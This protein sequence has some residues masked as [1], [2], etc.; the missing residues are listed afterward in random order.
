LAKPIRYNPGGMPPFI[1]AKDPLTSAEWAALN[2]T[3][4][5]VGNSTVARRIIETMGPLGAGIQTV[6]NEI[7][8]GITEGYKSILGLNGSAI[9]TK[10]RES[11]VVPIIFKDF[12]VHW[13]DLEEARLTGQGFSRAKAAAAA[14]SCARAE[15]KLVLFG[16]GRLGYE[17][18]MTAEGRNVITGFE[19]ERPGNAFKN[20]TSMIKVLA[21]KGYSGPY[22]AIAHPKIYTGMHRVLAGSSLLEIAHV[23]ALLT[24]GVFRSELL[25][26]ETGLVIATGRQNF[27]LVIAVDT[28]AAFLGARKMNLPF[29]VLKSIYL[30][31]R[32]SDA[33]CTFAPK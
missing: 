15:D 6:P 33:I 3:I 30:R 13:R 22:A 24:A 9:K 11:A 27:E 14:S 29:R 26:P 23:R 5:V 19:W 20:F 8:V 17:G 31:I 25:K 7:M 10:A 18:L 12:I 16:D 28:S 4:K 1:H 2:H 32:R 21:D